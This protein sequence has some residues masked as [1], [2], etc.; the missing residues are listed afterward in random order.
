[1]YTATTAIIILVLTPIPRTALMALTQ[2]LLSILLTA[3]I[4][5]CSLMVHISH[6]ISRTTISTRTMRI[7]CTT[8]IT[9]ISTITRLIRRS[10]TLRE[11]THISH[12][13]SIDTSTTP[14]HTVITIII[15][16]AVMRF[17]TIA[18][19]HLMTRGRTRIIT[20]TG[21]A[22]TFQVPTTRSGQASP[23]TTR[24]RTHLSGPASLIPNRVLTTQSG[25]ALNTTIKA[26]ITQEIGRVAHIIMVALVTQEVGMKVPTSTVAITATVGIAALITVAIMA[27]A[28]IAALTMEAIKAAPGMTALITTVAIMAVLGKAAPIIGI[29][30]IMVIPTQLIKI[31]HEAHMNTRIME[32]LSIKAIITITT[33]DTTSLRNTYSLLGMTS[34]PVV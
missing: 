17:L 13:L 30:H 9:G 11:T 10:P 6:T 19:T 2:S 1:M 15:N 21:L 22:K 34:I 4:V 33:A 29:V 3:P 25:L 16:Q 8:T 27:T 31:I 7:N 28:G 24:T 23:T 12:P 18:T 32:A 5:I 20:L 14:I 26:H